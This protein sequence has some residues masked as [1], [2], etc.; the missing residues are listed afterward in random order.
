[1]LRVARLMRQTAAILTLSGV[2]TLVQA[3]YLA[4]TQAS[5]PPR[6]NRSPSRPSGVWLHC[7][8]AEHK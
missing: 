6:R 1:M 4:V 8:V 7:S 2:L 5:S 3:T